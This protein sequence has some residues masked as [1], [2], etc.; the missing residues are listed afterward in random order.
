[1]YAFDKACLMK[2]WNEYT[3]QEKRMLVIVI[4]LLVVVVLSWGRVHHDFQKGVK[5][6]YG[7]S[8]DTTEVKP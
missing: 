5:Y 8:A 2:K 3:K 7:V 4:V 6:F 1:M